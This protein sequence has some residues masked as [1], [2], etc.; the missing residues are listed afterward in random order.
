MIDKEIEQQAD[1]EEIEEPQTET[2]T[3]KESKNTNGY[4]DYDDYIAAGNDPEMFRGRKAF[5][6]FHGIESELINVKRANKD[7]TKN[8][9]TV[10]EQQKQFLR[11][12]NE[13]VQQ[14]NEQKIRDLQDKLND[15]HEELDSKKAVKIQKEIDK[16]EIENEN[17][18][19]KS[20]QQQSNETP[21]SHIEEVLDFREE[22]PE[23]D[24]NSPDYNPSLDQTVTNLVGKSYSTQMT[25]RQV[26]RLLKTAYKEARNSSPR[27]ASNGMKIAP[28]S[29][30]PQK[31]PATN[32]SK[33]SK[34]A[35]LNGPAKEI[36]QH[37]IDNKNN[38]AAENF[39]NSVE[40]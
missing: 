27:Y 40:V 30:T 34:L 29:A 9:T 35:K 37:F 11:D 1:I 36:Y 33:A 15:A 18:K 31:K 20:D 21:P 12:Q 16:I 13:K 24:P 2:E 25:D 32:A 26:R 28:N 14:Q 6:Q 5:N 38:E 4:M 3:A 22:V 10:L 39:L 23:L 17:S 19:K 7:L 8:V